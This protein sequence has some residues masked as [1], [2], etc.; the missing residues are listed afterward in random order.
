MDKEKEK[1]VEINREEA[2]S[3][4]LLAELALKTQ[5]GM[6][7]VGSVHGVKL[8]FAPLFDEKA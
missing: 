6:A 4:L 5:Q 1:T 7:V 8:K 3:I 2:E